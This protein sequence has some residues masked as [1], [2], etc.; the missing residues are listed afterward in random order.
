MSTLIEAVKADPRFW[1]CPVLDTDLHILNSL[2]EPLALPDH[3]D[4]SDWVSEQEPALLRW[5]AR[6]TCISNT[7]RNYETTPTTPRII[8]RQILSLQ[9][10]FRKTAPIGVT[11]TMLL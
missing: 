6:Q 7:A 9:F 8:S 2:G 1:D 10:T 4:A 11:K 3:I 5:F